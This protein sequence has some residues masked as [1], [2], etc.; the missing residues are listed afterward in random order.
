MNNLKLI[1]FLFFIL[2]S[3]VY[4]GE[5]ESSSVNGESFDGYVSKPTIFPLEQLITDAADLAGKQKSIKRLKKGKITILFNWATWCAPCKTETAIM[6]PVIKKFKKRGVNLIGIN[7]DKSGLD[8]EEVISKIEKYKKEYK[9][10][11][12]Q[13]D[14]R[15]IME[16]DYFKNL[17][18]P[19]NPY[20]IILDKENRI[21]FLN[22][23]TTQV[24]EIIKF[25]LNEENP[26]K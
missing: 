4:S 17:N 8:K 15:S 23:F 26:T 20:K 12:P 21:R 24:E 1:V 9:I 19:Y 16:K 5:V 14:V 2:W 25:L 7:H 13:I 11:W 6:A 18:L 10:S 22:P 3:N